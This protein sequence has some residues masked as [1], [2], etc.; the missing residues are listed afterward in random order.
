MGLL[1]VMFVLGLV[2]EIRLAFWVTL[3]IPISFIGALLFLPAFDVSLNMLSL[4]AFIV[5]LGL[6]VDDA[7]VVGEAVFTRRQRGE[8]I[9]ESAIAGVREVA[10]P[11]TFSIIT[12][13]VAFAPMLFVPG[14]MGKFFS[15][16]PVVVIAVLLLS[17]IESLFILP[18]HLAHRSKAISLF[19]RILFIHKLHEW[20]HPAQQRFSRLVETFVDR[21]FQP[22]LRAAVSFR[23]FTLALCVA[24]LIATWGLVA[25][26]RLKWTFFPRIESDVVYANLELPFGTAAEET[27]GQRVHLETS[28]RQALG[29]EYDEVA[30]G[31][32]SQTGTSSFGQVAGSHTAS[33]SLFMVPIDER[34]LSAAEVARRWREAAGDIPG[35][36][37][38]S[39]DFAT[40]PASSAPISIDLSH[41]DL[42]ILESAA[43]TLAQSLASYSGTIDIDDGFRE[44]KPQLDLKLRPEARTL[45]LTEADLARQVR[46]AFFGAEAVRQQRG[47]EEV[48]V[49]VRRP[50]EERSSLYAIENFMVRTSAG[51]EIPLSQAA[52]VSQGTSYTSITRRDGRRIATVTADVG[53]GVNAAQ[54]IADVQANAVPE[55]VASVPGLKA[56]PGGQQQE[57]Q[58]ALGALQLGAAIALIVML[59]LLAIVFRSYSQPFIVLAA[60]PFGFIGA[61]LG[62]LAMGFDL[63]LVSVMGI[64][65]LSGVLVND[66][67]ILVVAANEYRKTM[68]VRE[69]II[70]AGARR[71]R[72]IILTSLTT[73]CGLAPMIVETSMQ[74]RFLIPMAIS[75]GFGILF[76]TIVTLLLI[77]ALYIIFEDVRGV[78]DRFVAFVY[79]DLDP[80]DTVAES[81]AVPAPADPVTGIRVSDEYRAFRA[82]VEPGVRDG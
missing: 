30:R 73:F 17:L 51:G 43:A 65:A 28:L 25:G 82:S 53:P 20:V 60:V 12:T 48:R 54:I 64:V 77:P 32:S 80:A 23:W 7:I 52:T 35:A 67:L 21:V 14:T 8:G 13:C 38:L 36:E 44:G 74:A 3:G 66:S 37:R 10:V 55:L 31:L 70:A 62:H 81:D 16:I 40:G 46:G 57:Q 47:R 42:G 27:D 72:P 68:P 29:A 11:V 69:A 4:F 58:D 59:G 24:T 34:D 79:G 78:L 18:A 71:F 5:T 2:L 33:V 75:L 50:L 39:F 76:A 41:R 56:E 26:Q 45:G 22:G 1:L 63:S 61:A 15:V 6:V 19:T 9:V 49:F